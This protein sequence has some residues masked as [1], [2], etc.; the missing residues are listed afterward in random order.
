MGIRMVITKD[1]CISDLP[2]SLPRLM[3][4]PHKARKKVFS[5]YCD[6]SVPPA[7]IF[8]LAGRHPRPPTIMSGDQGTAVMSASRSQNR[9][10]SSCSDIEPVLNFETLTPTRRMPNATG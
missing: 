7:D 10:S 9:P 2:A 1:R 4:G 6:C 8:L 3:Q 5:R